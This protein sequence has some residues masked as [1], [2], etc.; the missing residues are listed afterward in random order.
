MGFSRQ[1]LRWLSVEQKRPVSRAS[2]WTIASA[3]ALVAGG[4]GAGDDAVPASPS[5]SKT[6]PQWGHVIERRSS[7]RAPPEGLPATTVV[8]RDAAA[9]DS[10]PNRRGTGA[11]VAVGSGVPTPPNRAD[12]S[13]RTG[14][15]AVAGEGAEEDADASVARAELQEGISQLPK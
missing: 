15:G 12:V 4:G 3:G 9:A 2:G 11:A 14:A 7:R 10:D 6:L 8:G 5:T 13:E 1:D